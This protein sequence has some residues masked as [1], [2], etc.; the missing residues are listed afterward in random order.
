MDIEDKEVEAQEVE[1]QEIEVKQPATYEEQV[2]KLKEHGCIIADETHA[3]LVLQKINYYRF[4][5]YFLSFQKNNGRIRK[6]TTFNNVYR[7]YLFDSKLR[8]LLFPVIEEIEIYLRV[9]LAYYHAHKYGTLGYMDEGNY[10][11]WH[12]HDK[13]LEKTKKRIEDNKSLLFVEHHIN[14]YDGKFPVWVMIELFTTNDLS[15]FYNDMS[16]ADKKNI[17]INSFNTVPKKLITWLH[18]LTILRNYCA[19][20][21]RLYYTLFTA[22]PLAPKDFSY[23]DMGIQIFDYILV[24]KFLYPYPERWI[25]SV[26]VPLRALIEEFKDSIKMQDIGFPEDWEDILEEQVVKDK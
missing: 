10:N 14:N 8:A 1:V 5:A 13:F 23:Q 25:S 4:S 3:K 20:Y 12:N 19:H 15:R 26:A 16:A 24:L 7:T 2:E 22:Q 17:A 6:G 18:C 11:N 9:Q 21:S